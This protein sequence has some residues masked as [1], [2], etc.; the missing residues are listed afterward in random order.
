[1]ASHS[2]RAGYCPDRALKT[3]PRQ[4]YQ[5]GFRHRKLMFRKRSSNGLVAPLRL[6]VTPVDG[7][8][9]LP[10]VGRKVGECHFCIGIGSFVREP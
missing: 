2:L 4:S 7:F 1:M 5:R 3:T 8:R 6:A 9:L 10:K